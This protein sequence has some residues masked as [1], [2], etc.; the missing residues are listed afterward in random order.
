MKLKTLLC[1]GLLISGLCAPVSADPILVPNGGIWKDH[2]SENQPENSVNAYIRAATT[3]NPTGGN[4]PPFVAVGVRKATVSGEEKLIVFSDHYWARM[5]D[6]SNNT[7][8]WARRVFFNDNRPNA[9]KLSSHGISSS[10]FKDLRLRRVN[11]EGYTDKTGGQKVELLDAFIHQTACE[12]DTKLWLDI[13][14]AEDLAVAG[15]LL[16]TYEC[17][18]NTK[19]EGT[20]LSQRVYV[21]PLIGDTIPE[22]LSGTPAADLPQAYV[23]HFG[24]DLTYIWS[25]TEDQYTDCTT[26]TCRIKDSWNNL[27]NPA[28]LFLSA[29]TLSQTFGISFTFPS[30]LERL[31]DAAD[32]NAIELAFLLAKIHVSS[33]TKL[34]SVGTRPHGAFLFDGKSDSGDLATSKKKPWCMPFIYERSKGEIEFFAPEL[35]NERN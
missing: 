17:P 32:V 18:K 13:Q 4:P 2:T 33:S 26:D 20:K 31:N 25:V 12:Y 6:Y 19:H 23:D 7:N 5:T 30:E 28:D 21:M 34:I 15:D 11:K 1:A 14:T 24:P 3:N 9:K 10:D 22:Q 8:N 16:I 35:Y 29:A 27:Y